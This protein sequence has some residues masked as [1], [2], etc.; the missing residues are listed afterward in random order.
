MREVEKIPQARSLRRSMTGAEERLWFHLRGRRLLNAKFRRQYAIGPY[1]ADFACVESKLVVE[2]DGSQHVEQA[3]YDKKRDAYIEEQGFTILRFWNNDVL[4][5]TD[6]VLEMIASHISP[7]PS[8]SAPG[9][10]GETP[11]PVNGR[12]EKRA[13]YG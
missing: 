9:R 6:D 13:S 2:L 7:H 10:F 1:I 12:R 11:S 5:K 3:G 8:A 4:S